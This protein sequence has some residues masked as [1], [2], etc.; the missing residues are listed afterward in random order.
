MIMILKNQIG[1][2]VI[3]SRKFK[4]KDRKAPAIFIASL[5][6]QNSIP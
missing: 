5:L 6:D 2:N 1:I 4:S 3:H